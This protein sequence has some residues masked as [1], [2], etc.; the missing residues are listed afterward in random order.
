MPTDG[1]WLA[2]FLGKKAQPVAKFTGDAKTAIWLPN[3]RVAKAWVESEKDG[4]VSD[5]TP[6]VR[7]TAAG[8]FPFVWTC[9]IM[10]G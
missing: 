8:A 3:E 6:T 5:T 4:H 10:P 7:K 1:A 9:R 2:P